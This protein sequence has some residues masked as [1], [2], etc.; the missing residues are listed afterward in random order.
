MVRAIDFQL[1]RKG[2]FSFRS[3]A[4]RAEETA[5]RVL[6][7]VLQPH[8][9][10]NFPL[11]A[12]DAIVSV[13][14]LLAA[15][16]K[17]SV[18]RQKGTLHE[19]RLIDLP[20]E[21]AQ[22]DLGLRT[23]LGPA[24]LRAQTLAVKKAVFGLQELTKAEF[25]ETG[26][27]LI[28]DLKDGEQ[29]I[30]ASG[31]LDKLNSLNKIYGKEIMNHV[32]HDVGQIIQHEAEGMIGRASDVKLCFGGD[33]FMLAI[34]IDR[35]TPGFNAQKALDLL[36]ESVQRNMD[37][38]YGVALLPRFQALRQ[39]LGEA[40]F[41]KVCAAVRRYCAV[42]E[43]RPR[44][45][46]NLVLFHVPK[47]NEVRNVMTLVEA[48]VTQD[49]KGEGIDLELELSADWI[50]GNRSFNGGYLWT[51]TVS[52]GAVSLQDVCEEQC[53]PLPL[54]DAKM[55]LLRRL[56]EELAHRA[57]DA[58][59]TAKLVR[60]AVRTGKTPYR[61]DHSEGVSVLSEQL[62]RQMDE[63][64]A[65]IMTGLTEEEYDRRD[66]L[67]LR[68]L[69]QTAFRDLVA[70]QC[71][72]GKRGNLIG[73]EAVYGG[74]GLIDEYVQKLHATRR[75]DLRGWGGGVGLRGINK[76]YGYRCGDEIIKAIAEA[77]A[78]TLPGRGR[79]MALTR[80]VDKFF[81]WLPLLSAEE[82]AGF[83]DRV[84]TE[85]NRLLT[86]VN[87]KNIRAAQ[88]PDEDVVHSGQMFERLENT[89]QVEG[90]ARVLFSG[91]GNQ[92]KVYTPAVEEFA[93]T[94]RE[95]T[96]EEFASRLDAFRRDRDEV[97][98]RENIDRY[99]QVNFNS[100]QFA[101]AYDRFPVGTSNE[102]FLLLAGE[103][104][105]ANPRILDL[106]T[107]T[108]KALLPFAR[109]P[110]GSVVGVDLQG[111]MLEVARRNHQKLF[112][113]LDAKFIQ[114]DVSEL[115]QLLKAEAPFD[116]ATARYFI[117]YMDLDGALPQIRQVLRPGGRLIFNVFAGYF[118][119]A[120]TEFVASNLFY[121]NL[122][123][124]TKEV[125]EEEL[126]H[127]PSKFLKPLLETGEIEIRDGR[128]MIVGRAISQNLTREYLTR[129]LTGAGFNELAFKRVSEWYPF[130]AKR[131]FSLLK[132]SLPFYWAVTNGMQL[133]DDRLK[134]QVIERVYDK[135][136]GLKGKEV[137]ETNI[138]VTAS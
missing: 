103:A 75:D 67:D 125:L 109:L 121:H 19:A 85:A 116:V 115:D 78:R 62:L 20:L 112:P 132:R 61:H 7:V 48:Q 50:A 51:P 47:G 102:Q 100:V 122:A 5:R 95:R 8:I 60:N 57:D 133:E 40:D 10:A 108:G 113:Q 93:I 73:F 34:K 58:L 136:R 124:A 80:F 23:P 22:A 99:L 110:R 64:Q 43:D 105:S 59:H 82:L 89:T 76:L 138:F 37:K 68:L 128:V 79:K 63:V 101:E 55:I 24:E 25:R 13:A 98:T 129:A 39:R 72:A 120:T 69:S 27:N 118:F 15:D 44:E 107:G 104:L 14:G 77:V 32:L 71:S 94:A 83:V 130:D 38:R 65:R 9:Q 33:E 42:L 49:L 92:I 4:A 3:P 35:G 84:Q 46:G 52:I 11:L 28:R 17:L 90:G 137:M 123:K 127:Y 1:L 2:A 111:S 41:A 70:A 134:L 131:E 66:H 117:N 119:G 53:V 16:A 36:R 88:V 106:G 21:K 114:G 45:Y 126:N 87:L 54:R 6:G 30:V 74:E 97:V 26:L 12:L 96:V 135:L 91:G 18:T 29:L 81:L 56:Q 31:D 86:G